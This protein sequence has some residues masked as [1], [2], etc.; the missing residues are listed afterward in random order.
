M[1]YHD[2]I[3]LA[4]RAASHK[5]FSIEKHPQY[6]GY[7]KVLASVVYNFSDKKL[8]GSSANTTTITV[9]Q[10]LLSITNH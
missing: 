2:F 3:D 5:L 9:N 8:K 4:R 10:H 1:I 6:D 7:H